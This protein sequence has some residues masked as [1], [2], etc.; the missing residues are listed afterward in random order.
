MRLVEAGKKVWEV[1]AVAFGPNALTVIDELRAMQAEY[2]HA[3]EML[4]LIEE[5]VPASGPPKNTHRCS[6][7]WDD[8]HQL[9]VGPKRGK[10]LRVLWFY[11]EGLPVVRRRIICTSAFYKRDETS[12]A[13]VKTASDVLAEY[14]AAKASGKLVIE[15]KENEP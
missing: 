9:K 11:D 1:L 6:F 2:R 13:D 7:L 5:Y 12:R 8:I 3:E 15:R 4:A 14:I 10:K